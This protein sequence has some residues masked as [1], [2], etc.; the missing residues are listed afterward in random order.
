[1]DVALQVFRGVEVDDVTDPV[2]VDPTGRDIRRDQNALTTTGERCE[3]LLARRLRLVTMNGEGTHTATVKVTDQAVGTMPGTH[4]HQCQVALALQLGE[5]GLNLVATL[6][7]EEAVL[8]V[9]NIL[10]LDVHFVSGS[11]IGVASGKLADGPIQRRREEERLVGAE[12]LHDGVDLR[13][14]AHVEHPV[15]LI[16]DE[17]LHGVNANF[18]LTEEVLKAAWGRDQ[19]VGATCGSNLAALRDATVDGLNRDSFRGS[20]HPKLCCD[21]PRK[22]ACR[23]EDQTGGTAHRGTAALNHRDT[24]GEGLARTRWGLRQDVASGHD[25]GDDRRLNRERGG[26]SRRREGIANAS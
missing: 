18:A 21:L 19:D 7:T 17:C 23:D 26:D 12:A 8:H 4:E 11:V 15:S 16:Q 24:E 20:D 6:G 13:L 14:E 5:Q 9:A 25:I 10:R 3:R 2:D 22:L 1:M